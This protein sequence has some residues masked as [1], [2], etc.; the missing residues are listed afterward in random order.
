MQ[1][2]N[3]YAVRSALERVFPDA[4]PLGYELR[5][6]F[7]ERWFRIHSLPFSK[8]LPE[9]RS[10]RTALYNRQQAV[11]S[12]LFGMGTMV[13]VLIYDWSGQSCI[14]RNHPLAA[15]VPEDLE[16]AV[17]L[18]PEDDDPYLPPTSIYALE[19][20]WNPIELYQA[21]QVVAEDRASFAVFEAVGGGFFAP[22]D[23]GADMFYPSTSLRE[24]AMAIFA[25][26]RAPDPSGL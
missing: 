15:L 8:R 16:P 6:R 5:E 9:S 24:E 21:I 22:Y 17:I 20:A 10:D 11:A 12:H 18:P 23:G 25:R 19:F 14:P 2:A 3:P 13:I 26:I 7:P 4:P 1:P